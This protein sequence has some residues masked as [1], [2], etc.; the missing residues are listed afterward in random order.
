MLFEPLL[1]LVGGKV[2]VELTEAARL[3]HHG[4][5][6]TLL[7]RTHRAHSPTQPNWQLHKVDTH[8][9]GKIR[10]ETTRA[11]QEMTTPTVIS[12]RFFYP[13]L[14]LGTNEGDPV[15]GHSEFS[16]LRWNSI[17]RLLG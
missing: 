2:A 1:N 11:S 17:W 9:T 15:R 14:N 8:Q 12:L 13:E 10:A 16:G 5:V 6:R 4:L 7:L 3:N